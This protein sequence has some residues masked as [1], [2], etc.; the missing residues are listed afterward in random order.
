MRTRTIAVN[1]EVE[2]AGDL[3]LIAR[4]YRWHEAHMTASALQ[5]AGIAAMV[6]DAQSH[7]TMP[8]AGLA[9]G[10]MRIVV[11]ASQSRE[12]DAL[13]ATL[14]QP[15]ARLSLGAAI[16]LIATFWWIGIFSFQNVGPMFSGVYQRRTAE[17]AAEE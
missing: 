7:S 5:S 6:L 9:L 8:E 3:V 4:A 10:G 15:V 13:V 1:G 16:F 14:P 12:A 17:A 2:N 11:P